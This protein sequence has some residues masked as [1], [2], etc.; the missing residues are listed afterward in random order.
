MAADGD[1]R[2]VNDA[3]GERYELWLGDARAG[4]IQYQTQPGVIVL[5][6]T[7][8]GPEFEGRG[9]ATRLVADAL[10]DVRARGL[11]LVPVCSFVRDYLRNHP[12]QWDLV[13]PRAASR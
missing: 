10:Q 5:I 12:E 7:E 2:F 9:L 1:P 4:S 6:H 13:L 8:I 11:K 3:E